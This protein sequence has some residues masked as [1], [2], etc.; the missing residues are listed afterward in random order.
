MDHHH[1]KF[2]ELLSMNHEPKNMKKYILKPGKHQFAPGAHAVHSNDN[3]TDEEAKWYLER[4]PHIA[5]L[6]VECPQDNESEGP[7]EAESIKLKGR[8]KRISAQKQSLNQL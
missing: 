6:F 7:K 8:R 1:N 3:L 4:Y 2:H 5:G